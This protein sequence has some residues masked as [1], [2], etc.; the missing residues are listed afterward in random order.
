M[1]LYIFVSVLLLI[2]LCYLELLSLIYLVVCVCA[3][4]FVC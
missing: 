3:H 4:V 2:G 1:Y